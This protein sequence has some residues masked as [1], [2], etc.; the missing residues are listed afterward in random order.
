MSFLL[1]L[2]YLLISLI[3]QI[4]NNIF[5]E[6][7]FLFYVFDLG[8]NSLMMTCQVRTGSGLVN[9]F[10]LRGSVKLFP[11]LIS[12]W[13]IILVPCSCCGVFWGPKLYKRWLAVRW[14]VFIRWEGVWSLLD[15]DFVLSSG[16]VEYGEFPRGAHNFFYWAH[17][18][19]DFQSG[20]L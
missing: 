19:P 8:Q 2:I 12:L 14:S 16:S 5:Q 20:R 17:F 18:V 6:L 13:K 7:S 4:L 1:I 3:G 10:L 9:N 15:D 11:F